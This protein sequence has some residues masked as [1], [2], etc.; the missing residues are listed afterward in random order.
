M[1]FKS[2][3]DSNRVA[4]CE[5]NKACKEKFHSE[6]KHIGDYQLTDLYPQEVI[7]AYKSR[8]AQITAL[9]ATRSRDHVSILDLRQL[10][11]RLLKA[12]CLAPVF[13]FDR[14]LAPKAAAVHK[15]AA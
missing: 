13:K 8:A 1:K 15:L 10:N 7:D 6:S 14:W 2:S 4:T 3:W 11:E 9:S 5:L 12:H